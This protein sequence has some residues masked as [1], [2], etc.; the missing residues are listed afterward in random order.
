MLKLKTLRVNNFRSFKGEHVFT[1]PTT[2]GLYFLTGLNEAQ[3]KLG[4]NGAGKSTFLEAIT[5][6]LYGRTTR[7]LKAND[8]ITWGLPNCQGELELTIGD[9]VACIKRTQKPNAL[10]LDDKPVDQE[11]LEKFLRLNF[12]AFIYSVLNPQ[13]GTSFFNLSP[14]AKL[15]LFSEIMN[16]NFW[17]TKSEEA[18]K[19]ASQQDVE[20]LQLGN[21]IANIQG[22]LKTAD[23]DIEA[24]TQQ[25]SLFEKEQDQ[26]IVDCHVKAKKIR[27]EEKP[28]KADVIK[29]R[30]DEGLA[31]SKCDNQK[32]TVK[33][34][35]NVLSETL[36]RIKDF[37][38]LKDTAKYGL[39]TALDLHDRFKNKMYCPTC[40]QRIDKG[41]HSKEIEG[42][43]KK[44]E[45]LKGD[46]AYYDTLLSIA[47]K[48]TVQDKLNHSKE[49]FKLSD[50]EAEAKKIS[51]R[52]MKQELKLE[53]IGERLDALTVQT[54]TLIDETNPFSQML[55]D[56]KDSIRALK[57]EL[58]QTV[59]ARDQLGVG[60]VA[61]SFW[62]KGFKRIRLFIIEQAFQSLEIEINN[63][64]AQLGMT[65]W[66]VTFAIERENKSGSMT[67]GFI[68]LIKGPSNKT[69]VKWENWSGG[70]TQRLQ[71]A[72]DLGLANLIMQ[73]AGLRNSVEFYDEPS[74]H[75]SQE[76]MLDLADTLHERATSENKTIWIV[77]HTSIANFGD[78]EGIIT[79]RKDENGSSID[80]GAKRR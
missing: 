19:Q 59:E 74:T 55:T 79:I 3:P 61:T 24:L 49:L 18:S 33:Q 25:E 31:L 40:H 80:T 76:G 28:L 72:G 73:Q 26:R 17:L 43:L 45:K 30:V 68:V 77:D 42:Q 12:E 37:S 4:S 65:D 27:D 15:S 46:I 29:L 22:Q 23:Q 56:K 36:N 5:W 53:S 70:E 6:I 13:F 1:F 14:S 71:L 11:E 78:F 50:Y 39:K 47:G 21:E 69:P 52:L 75:L 10:L 66:Q 9:R 16:L 44:A 62:V 20:I 51:Q 38:E 41:D 54:K 64:L 60:H 58:R 2:E 63:S 48:D 35:E 7:G 67:K 8:V 57:L 34:R 32:Q